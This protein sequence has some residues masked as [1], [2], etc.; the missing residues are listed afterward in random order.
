MALR[1]VKTDYP[2]SMEVEGITQPFLDDGPTLATEAPR[3][4]ENGSRVVRLA[5]LV[6]ALLAFMFFLVSPLALWY[7]VPYA[8]TDAQTNATICAERPFWTNSGSSS[9]T[10]EGRWVDDDEGGGHYVETTYGWWPEPPKW[11]DSS[12]SWRDGV[13]WIGSGDDDVAVPLP[14]NWTVGIPCST[15]RN[16]MGGSDD[17]RLLQDRP[18]GRYG[19]GEYCATNQQQPSN[20]SFEK[21]DGHGDKTSESAHWLSDSVPSTMCG[22]PTLLAPCAALFDEPRAPF[23]SYGASS[24]GQQ[25]NSWSV[26]QSNC[27]AYVDNYVEDNDARVFQGNSEA[28]ELCEWCASLCVICRRAIRGQLRTLRH[29]S[30]QVPCGRSNLPPAL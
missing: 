16:L 10:K 22:A 9:Y 2:T 3:R 15:V 7:L 23:S 19:E 6:A 29:L 18:C 14:C 5:S 27:N 4:G 1:K 21:I 26:D 8:P 13:P 30:P 25:Y 20:S 28:Y 12:T 17:K 11:T 24:D